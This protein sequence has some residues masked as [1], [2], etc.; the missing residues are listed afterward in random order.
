MCIKG[1]SFFVGWGSEGVGVEALSCLGQVNSEGKWAGSQWL[2]WC[3]ASHFKRIPHK[4][5]S[6]TFH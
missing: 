3:F 2:S 5:H 4:M 1:H 6:S